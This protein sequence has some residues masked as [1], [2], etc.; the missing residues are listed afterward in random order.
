MFKYLGVFCMCFLLIGVRGS[1]LDDLKN[2]G[3]QALHT[4]LD[5][6]SSDG[7]KTLVSTAVSTAGTALL[8]SLFGKRATAEEMNQ[9]LELLKQEAETVRQIFHSYGAQLQTVYDKIQDMSFLEHNAPE[10]LDNIA[11]LKGQYNEILDRVVMNFHQKMNQMEH[12]RK[13]ALL[14][15]FAAAL[16]NTVNQLKQTFGGVAGLDR[17]RLSN[18][19]R[20]LAVLLV[21][22]ECVFLIFTDIWRCCWS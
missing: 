13:R 4:A 12:S 1:F 14:D 6:L 7:V 11:K 9:A 17:V 22:I 2:F 21:L 20:H 3:N 19:Y 18:L 16:Q 15:G 10:F 5:T 8:S